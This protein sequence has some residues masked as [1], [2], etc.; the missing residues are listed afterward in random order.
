MDNKEKREQISVT[1]PKQIW[2]RIKSEAIPILIA[3][4]VC[5]CVYICIVYVTIA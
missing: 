3:L 1:I 2:E 5:V 4:G